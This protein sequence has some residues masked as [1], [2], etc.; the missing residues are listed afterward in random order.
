LEVKIQTAVAEIASRD[1][2]YNGQAKRRILRTCDLR[3]SRSRSS[4]FRFKPV[5][6][7]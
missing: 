4:I 1:C 7:T 5:E 3:N 2:S 6:S